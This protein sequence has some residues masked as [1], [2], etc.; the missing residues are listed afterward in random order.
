MTDARDNFSRRIFFGVGVG[1]GLLVLGLAVAV[2]VWRMRLGK[3]VNDRLSALQA[4]GYPT[5]GAELNAW[6]ASVPDNE[7]AGLNL[8][9]AFAVMR[10]VI[11]WICHPDLTP[12]CP[13]WR[14]SNRSPRPPTLKLAS[15]SMLTGMRT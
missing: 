11:R 7:N 4:A 2:I 8:G 3:E 1:L 13:I 9:E 10:A 12:S 6:Y 14:K 5:S 15:P